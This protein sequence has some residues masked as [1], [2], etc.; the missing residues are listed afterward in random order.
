MAPKP[1]AGKLGK[2]QATGASAPPQQ[3]PEVLEQ[4]CAAATKGQKEAMLVALLQC[5]PPKT[6]VLEA[7]FKDV[8]KKVPGFQRLHGEYFKGAC[9]RYAQMKSG[10]QW[11]L[12]DDFHQEALNIVAGK[13]AAAGAPAEPS[14]AQP[15]SGAAHRSSAD[16]QAAAQRRPPSEPQARNGGAQL[17][18]QAGA[19][20]FKKKKKG[21]L[22]KAAD[23]G[24]GVEPMAV[25]EP[26][27]TGLKRKM[28]T[29]GLTDSDSGEE[30]AIPSKPYKVQK[31]PSSNGYPTQNGY[32]PATTAAAPTPQLNGFSGHHQDQQWQDGRNGHQGSDIAVGTHQPDRLGAEG[33][34]PSQPPMSVGDEGQP[35][36]AAPAKV[37]KLTL[38]I[39]RPLADNYK[40]SWFVE[41]VD[42]QPSL[43]G[44]VSSID[45]WEEYLVEYNSKHSV[46][47]RL[48]QEM[49]DTRIKV[50][51]LRQAAHQA[52]SDSERL[53]FQQHF[54][55]LWKKAQPRVEKWNKAFSVLDK[56]LV[57]L[58][59][60]LQAF[61]D[62]HAAA[63]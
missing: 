38:K 45:Q 9:R 63:T 34:S 5:K 6:S 43:K 3:T 62:M 42:R 28:Q 29:S 54:D 2:G 50:E 40:E 18:P 1:H 55:A 58:H 31:G 48:H 53:K 37:G 47:F 26:S 24:G 27:G 11:K 7:L 20:Q 23:M 35:D 33:R 25:Q 44:P 52:T 46:Y 56:E 57:A 22:T 41:H 59:N 17:E 21:R 39:K 32:H 51:G 30:G 14:A 4:V 8:E 60:H 16:L 49:Q 13:S 36:T 12:K 61:H 19:D 15:F 10:N